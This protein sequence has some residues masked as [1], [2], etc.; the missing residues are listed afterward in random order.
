[1]KQNQRRR[2]M[3]VLWT[4]LAVLA[5]C[6]VLVLGS[7]LLRVPQP[8]ET[9]IPGRRGT[10]PATIQLPGKLS[11]DS[12]MPLVVL[13]HGFTGNRGG[14]THFT[15]LADDLAEEGMVTVRMDFPG[16]GQ[17]AEPQTAYTLGNMIADVDDIIAYMQ[18]TYHTD[19]PVA[20]VGHSMGGRV[21]SLYPRQ[22]SY[23]VEALVLWSPANG[24]GLQG[25]EFLNIDD[26]SQVQALADEA[27]A[28]GKATS[29]KWNTEISDVF[30]QEMRD[31]DP[32]AA[33]REAGLPVLLTYAGHETLFTEQTVAE[34]IA[35]V[36]SLPGSQVVLDPFVDGDHN[37]F[38]PSGKED[39]QTPVMDQALR[40]ATET[41]LRDTLS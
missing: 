7:L 13:C 8:L 29:A 25:L 34:T 17:S 5:L 14:D 32:N 31:S 33:L 4:C 18:E 12:E 19:G 21:A 38:G 20:L 39:P 30:V 3:L 40:E 22:G 2:A 24:T 10:I 6:V 41:F 23:P 9:Q 36:Q 35:A 28:N 27:L 26:F 1:M 16:C 37:Y 11:R 15:Q